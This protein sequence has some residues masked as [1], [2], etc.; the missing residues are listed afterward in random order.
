M[1]KSKK[2]KRLKLVMGDKTYETLQVAHVARYAAGLPDQ[3]RISVSSCIWWGRFAA[4]YLCVDL[5]DPNQ[6]RLADLLTCYVA[7]FSDDN[8]PD[9]VICR[10]LEFAG[11]AKFLSSPIGSG[12]FVFFDG[13]C[14]TPRRFLVEIKNLED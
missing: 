6:P 9:F 10:Y 5:C 12:F 8:C 4:L 7:S 3:D 11:L 13:S 1:F 14:Y 2:S